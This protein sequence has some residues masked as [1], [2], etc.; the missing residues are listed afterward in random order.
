MRC[1]VVVV[2]FLQASDVGSYVEGLV[3]T[4][5]VS[6]KYAAAR[7]LSS[8]PCWFGSSDGMSAHTYIHTYIHTII[9]Y[10]HTYIHTYINYIHTL[11]T[12]IHTY[13]LTLHCST[14]HYTTLHF[15]TYIHTNI[16]TQHH[17]QKQD[18]DDHL[19]SGQG[20]VMLH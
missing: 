5:A 15:T 17:L 10:I 1:V 9:T 6:V 11:I 20:R 3:R 4:S 2:V 12:Y 16:H 19:A 7:G 13:I 8:A 18:E 14:L